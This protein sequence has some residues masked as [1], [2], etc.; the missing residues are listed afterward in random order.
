MS[1]RALARGCVALFAP[2]TAFPVL[3]A[4]LRMDRPPRWLGVAAGAV[5]A[6]LSGAAAT[7]AT[8]ARGAVADR[9]RLAAFRTSQHVVGVVPALLATYFVLGDRVDWTV[10]VVGLAWRGWLLHL[11][12]PS[13]AAALLGGR[14]AEAQER[15]AGAA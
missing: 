7:L 11:S 5:A 14:P 4:A 9:H 10:L 6:I 2:S 13:L 12:L 8:R 1:L 3:A 15:A